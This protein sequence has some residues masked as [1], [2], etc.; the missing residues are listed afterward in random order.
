MRHE[1]PGPASA[2][3]RGFGDELDPATRA[4]AFCG[5]GDCLFQR[6]A[7]MSPGSDDQRAT[8]K[9]A[10]MSYLRVA[11]NY[12]NETRYVS[13]SLFFAARSFDLMGEDQ[14]PNAQKLYL[15]VVRTYGDS[16]W[17]KESKSFIK[18]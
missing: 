11:I 17:A 6:A 12:K 5:L 2:G 4:A 13:K 8:L 10:L 16:Q 18:R 15:R 1:Q 14:A 9:A 3:G 7:G